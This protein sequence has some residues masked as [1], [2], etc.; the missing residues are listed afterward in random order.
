[1]LLTTKYAETKGTIQIEYDANEWP[2][3]QQSNL[4][5]LELANNRIGID[6]LSLTVSQ[7]EQV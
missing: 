5:G 6:Q 2:D 7:A 4:S 1:M 3:I